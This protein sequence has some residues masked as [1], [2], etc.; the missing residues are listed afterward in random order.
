MVNGSTAIDNSAV[1]TKISTNLF[2]VGFV[3]TSIQLLLIREMMNISGGYELMTGTFLAS[4]LI[5]SA[6]GAILA[7]RSSLTI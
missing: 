3:S 5:I 2:I 1:N 6:A 7:G 4:W